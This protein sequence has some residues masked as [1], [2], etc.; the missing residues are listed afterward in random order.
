LSFQE[1]TS[2]LGAWG[3]F[4]SSDIFFNFIFRDFNIY[5][6]SFSCLV[7]ITPRL[8]L[9]KSLKKEIEGDLRRWEDFHAHGLTGSI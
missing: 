9:L 2:D 7:R 1:P 6:K 8:L 4:P 5:I 3:I